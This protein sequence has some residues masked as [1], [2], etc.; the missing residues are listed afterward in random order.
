MTY[1]S[2]GVDIERAERALQSVVDRIRATHDANVVGGAGGFGGMYAGHFPEMERP[3]LVSSIDGVGTKTRVAAMVG[4]YRGLGFDIVHHCVDDILC[5]GARPL[6]FLDYFACSQLRG[7]RFEAVVGGIA[8][9]CAAHGCALIG[10]ETAEMPGVY[11]DDEIDIVGTI[12]GVVDMDRRL[13]KGKMQ[14]GDVVIGIGSDG[15][16]TNGFTLARRAL[17]EVGGLSVRDF[18]PGTS[19][20]IGEALLMPH[21]SY[22]RSVWPLVEA[23]AVQALAHITGGGFHDNIPRVLAS[24][25][26]V[27]IDRRSWQPPAIFRL[28]Q[29]TGGIA[30]AEMFRTFNMGIGMVAIVSRDDAPRCLEALRGAGEVATAIGEV[31]RG[32]R[33]VQIV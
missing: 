28:I 1:A 4:D 29:D 23:G 5:Q 16:H 10:G 2:A 32:S 11:V 33:D 15:L 17:F 22:L 25:V 30:D 27:S 3:V 24:D 18:V 20:T 31:Q 14:P 8:D 21:R 9:A 13:P 26:Q 7:D 19:L 12:V 6:F